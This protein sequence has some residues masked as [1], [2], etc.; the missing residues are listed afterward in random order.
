MANDER[1]SET[2]IREVDE[3]LRREQLQ[4]LWNRFGWIFIGICVLIVLIT[5]GYRGWIWWEERQAAQAG[6]RFLAALE[7]MQ[8][9]DRE[10]GE[11]AL[12]AIADGSGGYAALARLRLA[13]INAAAGDDE[14]ALADYD[15]LVADGSLSQSI[16]ELA[17]VRA[18]LLALD[19]GDTA[20]ATER[21][22]PL[23]EAGNPWRHVVRDIL[24]TAA[25]QEG[26][27]DE[28]R[29]YFLAIQ[30]DAE[31]PPTTWVRAGMM[32]SLIDGELPEAGSD[33]AAPDTQ[34]G[35]QDDAAA[36]EMSSDQG[37]EA[38]AGTEMAPEAGSQPA[39]QLEVPEDAMPA[40]DLE[41]PADAA[42]E[43][44]PNEAVDMAPEVAPETAADGAAKM[45]PE[46]AEGAASED[47]ATE[48]SPD[49][50][51]ELLP[52][53]EETAEPAP[54]AESGQ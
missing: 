2:F 38:A 21:A 49:G 10:E 41:A 24:G 30:Q 3:E 16:R 23:D 51:A 8:S 20:G 48:V 32:V 19:A 43:T 52:E 5:A 25:Y 50:A 34:E 9:G 22:E 46:A 40:M 14:A 53:A 12:Q 37:G 45:A 4:T 39:T 33:G 7:E 1:R 15:S 18:A 11:A 47:G 35:T 44:A 54:E 27:L 36:E 31:T 29:D 28:A 42:T 6:D 17:R 26:R 13:G